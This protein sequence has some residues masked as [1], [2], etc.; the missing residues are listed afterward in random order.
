MVGT[1]TRA[2][3]GQRLLDKIYRLTPGDGRGQVRSDPLKL[4]DAGEPFLDRDATVIVDGDER[5]RFLTALVDVAALRHAWHDHRAF[6]LV[7][8]PRMHM[9]QR[10]IVEAPAM[11]VGDLAGSV[12]V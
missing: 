4:G 5:D 2:S 12:E 3:V 6:A 10:P 9:P 7:P 11:H 8:R 1:G